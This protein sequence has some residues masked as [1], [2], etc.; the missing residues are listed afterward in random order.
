LWTHLDRA[1]LGVG[2]EIG[3]G[4]GVGARGFARF[5]AAGLLR[6]VLEEHEEE[7]EYVEDIVGVPHGPV[8]DVDHRSILGRACK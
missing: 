7:V 6:V 2:V 4:A 3:A 8:A 5:N 1:R